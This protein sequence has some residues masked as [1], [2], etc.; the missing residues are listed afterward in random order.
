MS[1]STYIALILSFGGSVLI[2]LASPHQLWLSHTWSAVLLRRMG[3]V[4]LAIS[5]T[6]LILTMQTVAAIFMLLV[7]LMLLLVL[8]PYIGALKALRKSRP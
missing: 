6:I 2:Y 3:F 1:M 8:F 7:W 4:L 5:L